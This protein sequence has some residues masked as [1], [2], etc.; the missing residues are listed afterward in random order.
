MLYLINLV[1]Y[2]LT[3]IVG[4]DPKQLCGLWMLVGALQMKV[5]GLRTPAVHF[6]DEVEGA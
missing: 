4:P 6:S 5:D 1:S 3:L 2:V